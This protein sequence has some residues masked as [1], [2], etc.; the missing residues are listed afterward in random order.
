MT[1]H[2]NHFDSTGTDPERSLKVTHW[3]IRRPY[4]HPFNFDAI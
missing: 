3:N 1:A 2:S 4:V